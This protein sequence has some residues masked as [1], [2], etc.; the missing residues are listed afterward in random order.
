LPSLIYRVGLLLTPY[1]KSFR[2][3]MTT[4]R[5]N[6]SALETS[7]REVIQSQAVIPKHLYIGAEWT[8]QVV[9]INLH[10]TIVIAE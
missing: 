5:E 10:A 2:Q 6:E 1:I 4:E 9:F 3:L 7:P 8:Q